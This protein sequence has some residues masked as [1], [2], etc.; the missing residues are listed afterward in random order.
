MGGLGYNTQVYKDRVTPLYIVKVNVVMH[1]IGLKPGE[2]VVG[3]IVNAMPNNLHH[4]LSQFVVRTA[5][6]TIKAS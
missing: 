3:P 4:R 2:Y 1:D 6:K 5:N